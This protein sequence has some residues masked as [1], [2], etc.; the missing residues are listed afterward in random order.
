MAGSA[1]FFAPLIRTVPSSLR[2]P[3]IL[4]LSMFAY[5][6]SCRVSSACFLAQRASAWRT[7]A[8]VLA[9]SMLCASRKRARIR[10]SPFQHHQRRGQIVSRLTQGVFRRRRVHS[11]G[12]L[13]DPRAAPPQL[14]ICQRD[15][16]HPVLI[17]PA[18]AH[19]R[20]SRKQVQHH[21]LRG[22]GLQP[23]RAG[24]RFGAG[25]GR[26]GDLRLARQWRM[27]VRCNADGDRAAPRAN[28]SAPRT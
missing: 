8:A 18:D 23:R 11:G 21:F 7:F 1:A 24:D 25:F 3:W 2:P 14:L 10:R 16:H 4:N 12:L 6:R 19:H 27:R 22:S 28:S 26:D 20:S 13:E 15:V 17:D 9:A 5:P